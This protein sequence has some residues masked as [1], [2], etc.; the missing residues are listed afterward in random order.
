[1][2]DWQ[3]CAKTRRGYHVWRGTDE[4]LA[5]YWQVTKTD[6]PPSGNSGGYFNLESLLKL[7]GDYIP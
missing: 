1:M 4:N 6:S 7:K 2:T 5:V 3:W